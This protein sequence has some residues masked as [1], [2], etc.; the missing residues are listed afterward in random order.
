[1]RVIWGVVLCIIPPLA[2]LVFTLRTWL[3]P[4][5]LTGIESELHELRMA[6]VKEQMKAKYAVD[7]LLDKHQKQK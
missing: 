6:Q 5:R 2:I 7:A 3:K 1:M 4:P